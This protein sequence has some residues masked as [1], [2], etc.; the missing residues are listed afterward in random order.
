MENSRETALQL[1]DQLLSGALGV[2]D[3]CVRYENLYNFG[4]PNRAE[5]HQ[6]ALFRSVFDVVV[7]YSPFPAER[8]VIPNYKSEEEVIGLVKSVRAQFAA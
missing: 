6:A 2:Q 8:K 5:E 3:F 1:M 4:W 7:W